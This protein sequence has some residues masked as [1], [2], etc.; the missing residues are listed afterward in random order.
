MTI[1][2]DH[3]MAVTGDGRR[4]VY[5]PYRVDEAGMCECP[6]G[7][8][9]FC[10][11]CALHGDMASAPSL[12]LHMHDAACRTGYRGCKVHGYWKEVPQ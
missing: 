6:A 3:S 4:L 8:R 5:V 12:R 9:N 1:S 10:F 2:H 7:W 11:G